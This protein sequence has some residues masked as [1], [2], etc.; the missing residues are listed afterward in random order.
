MA[1]VEIPERFRQLYKA[2]SAEDVSDLASA[3]RSLKH[4][5]KSAGEISARIMEA[6]WDAEFASWYA[7]VVFD[8]SESVELMIPIAPTYSPAYNPEAEKAQAAGSTGALIAG[9]GTVWLIAL[10]FLKID[11]LLPSLICIFVGLAFMWE[12]F[13]RIAAS[14]GLSRLFGACASLVLICSLALTF[15]LIPLVRAMDKE[16]LETYYV[17]LLAVAAL[18]PTGSSWLVF[19][20]ATN[21]AMRKKQAKG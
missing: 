13:A 12:G 9:I 6:G 20:L 19:W 11:D 15:V 1:L 2:A 10:Q 8:N 3:A 17:P 16:S 4:K 5:G 7:Q 18:L 14:K 21:S